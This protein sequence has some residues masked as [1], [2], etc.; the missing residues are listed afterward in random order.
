MGL[1]MYAYTTATP[2]LPP[3]DFDAPSDTQRIHYWRKHPNLHGWM[4]QLYVEKGGIATSFNC[5]NV[6]LTEADLDRLEDA[7]RRQRLPETIGFFFG[8]S[9]GSEAED[10]LAFIA[11]ARAAIARG[12]AV[13]YSSWW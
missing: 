3:V 5:V 8:L 2:H 13:F 11:L 6:A 9:D 7:I 4:Q 10:D 12:L 1:D